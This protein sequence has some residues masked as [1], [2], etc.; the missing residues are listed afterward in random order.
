MFLEQSGADTKTNYVEFLEATRRGGTLG[1]F[2]GDA[3]ALIRIWLVF[4]LPLPVLNPYD[5]MQA[6]I[7][8]NVLKSLP[9]PK[10]GE[11]IEISISH[12]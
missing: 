2:G 1:T 6:Q 10:K 9:S 8:L 5:N 4:S 3:R 7:I 12:L 11:K